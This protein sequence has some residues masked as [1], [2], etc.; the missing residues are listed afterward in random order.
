[1]FFFCR[2]TP[3]FKHKEVQPLTKASNQIKLIKRLRQQLRF[4]CWIFFFFYS[5][6]TSELTL[7]SATINVFWRSSEW[8]IYFNKLKKLKSYLGGSWKHTRILPGLL[9]GMFWNLYLLFIL[10]S[11][12]LKLVT[13]PSKSKTDCFQKPAKNFYFFIISE[14]S[15]IRFLFTLVPRIKVYAIY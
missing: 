10:K 12:L 6:K 3:H 9:K 8:V 2:S 13:Y 5:K 15:Y 14:K 11:R 4:F 7:P 1:M